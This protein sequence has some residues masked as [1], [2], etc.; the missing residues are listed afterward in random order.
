[1]EGLRL[2]C[3]CTTWTRSIREQLTYYFRREAVVP[4][5]TRLGMSTWRKALF[6]A[7]HLNANRTA[8]YFGVPATQVVEIGL[9]IEI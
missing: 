7:M 8:A 5:G 1:M 3:Q 4:V 2:A 9:E 6:S